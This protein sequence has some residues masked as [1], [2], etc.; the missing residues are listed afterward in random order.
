MRRIVVFNRVTADGYFA[1]VDRNLDW[2]VPDA[3]LDKAA[4]AATAGFDTML[5]GR[6]T[7]EMFEGFWPHAGDDSTALDPHGDGRRSEAMH[8][9]GVW[10]NEATKVVFSRTRKDVSWTNSRLL[11][12][13]DPR[14]VEA[15]KSGR[16]KD[17]IVFGSGSIVSK[18]TE[19]RLVD[20]YQ[21]VVGPLLLGDGRPMISGVPKELKL[22]LLEAKEYRSGNVMLRY[23]HPS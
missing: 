16:G 11:P 22:K 1:G 15:M 6:R 4:G 19:H 18:L 14:E 3:E 20:E 23:A 10:I 7:Y 17:M 12:E 9:M 21:L 8:A 2:V 13:F 5:F